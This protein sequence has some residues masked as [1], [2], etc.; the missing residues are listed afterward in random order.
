MKPDQ[1]M[2][3]VVN[4]QRYTVRTAKLLASDCYWD[5]R[6]FERHGRNVYLYRTRGGAY[7]TVTLSQWQGERDLL[8]PVSREAAIEL[9]EQELTEHEVEYEQ[10]FD[11]VVEE[12]GAGRPTYYDETMRQTALW[13]PEHMI[14]WL[15]AQPQPM[16]ETIRL[17]IDEAIKRG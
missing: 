5:G 9:Y 1:S 12:A 2:S 7:F 3:R 10:A 15:K 6:N 16:G 13:L 14:T 17:L 4:G 8:E 11:A